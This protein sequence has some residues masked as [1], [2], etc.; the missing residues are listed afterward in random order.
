MPICA[1]LLS[2]H[3]LG[4]ADCSRA[5]NADSPSFVGSLNSFC[6]FGE[7]LMKLMVLLV[8]RAMTEV[9]LEYLRSNAHTL[10]DHTPVHL[11]G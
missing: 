5:L 9:L 10:R 6:S 4:W 11:C 1:I 2:P 7:T 3:G 8:I